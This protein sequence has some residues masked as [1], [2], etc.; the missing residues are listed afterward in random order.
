MNDH[1]PTTCDDVTCQPCLHAECRESVIRLEVALMDLE[2]SAE[3]AEGMWVDL[4]VS[5]DALDVRN[6]L[7]LI[8]QGSR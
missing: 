4:P 8:R 6:V 5:V 7:D 2:V 1:D 3:G